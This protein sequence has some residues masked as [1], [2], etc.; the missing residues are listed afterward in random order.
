MAFRVRCGRETERPAPAATARPGL[1][2][3]GMLA[4]ASLF[5]LAPVGIAIAGWAA[6]VRGLLAWIACLIVVVPTYVV[7]WF[8]AV[9]DLSGALGNPF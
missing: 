3:F 9:A 1:D 5:V 7:I 6:G 4:W 2:L 8:M